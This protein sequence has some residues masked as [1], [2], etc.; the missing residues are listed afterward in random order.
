MVEKLNALLDNAN[1][2]GIKLPMIHD[3]KVGGSSVSLTMMFISFNVVLVGLIGKW[4]KYLDID[5]TQALYWFGICAS[6]Y[7]GRNLSVGGKS[8][9]NTKEEGN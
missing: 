7:F 6:L 5:I 4:S 9:T 3:P 1:K 8:V 2:V